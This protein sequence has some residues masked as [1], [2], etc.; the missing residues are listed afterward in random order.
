MRLR[1]HGLSLS[2]DFSPP[3]AE[4]WLACHVT[5][6]VPGFSGTFPCRVWRSDLESFHRQLVRMGEQIGVPSAADLTSTDP[7]IDLHFSMN[8]AGRIEGGYAFQNFDST[9]RPTLSGVFAMDQSYLPGLAAQ[10][11]ELLRPEA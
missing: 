4:D 9:G 6:Q 11:A 7:G 1:T 8:R 5:V 2:L 3:N 10:I